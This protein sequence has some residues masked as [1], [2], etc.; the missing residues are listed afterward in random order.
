LDVAS[1]F[2]R[3][4]LGLAEQG[5]GNETEARRLFQEVADFNFNSVDFALVRADAAKR[6]AAE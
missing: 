4:Q 6:A 2:P 3:Y 1:L 5:A